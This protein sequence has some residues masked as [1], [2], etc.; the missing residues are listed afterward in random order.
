MR[1]DIS[2]KTEY[3]RQVFAPEDALLSSIDKETRENDQPIHIGSDEGKLLEFLIRLGGVTTAVE[4]GTLAG[5][6]SIWIARALPEDGHLY[7]IEKDEKRAKICTEN[8]KKAGLV[9]KITLLQGDGHKKLTELKEKAPFD[10]IF[11]DA[12]K[13]GY[14]KY[15]DWAEENLNKGGLIIGDNTFLFGA[16]YDDAEKGVGDKSK[17]VMQEFNQRLADK[18]KYNSIIIPTDEGMTVAQKLF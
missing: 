2:K 6:S 8:F 15:L 1:T 4:V 10:M 3:I 18:T 11:I 9:D 12:E 13:A 16:V 5:Y 14:C 17:K 7:T